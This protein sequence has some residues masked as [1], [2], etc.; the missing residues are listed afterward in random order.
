MGHL[1]KQ[2]LSTTVFLFAIFFT[3]RGNALPNADIVFV[4]QIPNP[5]DFASANATFGNHLPTVDAIPRGGDLYIRYRDGTLKNLTRTAGLGNSGFQGVSSIAVRDPAVHWNGQKIIF[6]MVAGS[7]AEQYQVRTFHWQLYEMTGL[8]KDETPVVTRVPGQPENYNN[9]TPL[10][11]TDDSIIF[12]SD[13]P[14]NG[15][16]HLYPQRDEYESQPTTTG[17]WSLNPLTGSLALLDHTPSGAFNPTLDSY[18]RIVY[19]RWDHLQRDQQA[20]DTT[21]YGAFNF[22]SEAPGS[23]RISSSLEVFPEER[24]RSTQMNPVATTHSFNHFFPWQLNEDGTEHETLNHVGRHELHGYFDRSFNDDDNLQEHYGNDPSPTSGEIE[25]FLHIREDP[26][27]PGLYYGIDTPEFRTHAAGQIVSLTGAPTLNADQMTLTYI[28]DRST[29]RTDDDSSHPEHTGLYRDPLPLSDGALVASHTWTKVADSN[30]G[31]D[32]APR[33]R[34][35]FRLKTLKKV[36]A[37]W[38]PD[39]LLTS[40]IQGSVSYFTP[41]VRA[42]YVGAL[43]E[44]Q[45]VELIA[46]SRPARR[47]SHVQAPEQSIFDALGVHVDTLKAELAQKGLALI[48]MRNVTSRDGNDLQQPFNLRIPGSSLS[49]VKTTGKMYD[50]SALQIFQG[51]LI[52]GYGGTTDPEPGR[53]VLAQQLH[54]GLLAN[55]PNSNGPPASVRI[56]SDGSVAALVPARRA[57]TWQLTNEAGAPVV[58]ERYWL[59]FQPG[60]IRVCASCHGV[61]TAD[62]LGRPSPTNPPLA[63]R[64]LLSYVAQHPIPANPDAPGSPS[65][66][67]GGDEGTSKSYSLSV[68]GRDSGGR[69]IDARLFA[70]QRA[71]ILVRI[72]GGGSAERL[73]LKIKVNGA[74]CSGSGMAVTTTPDGS[75]SRSGISPSIPRRELVL[76]FTLE[77]ASAPLATQRATLFNKRASSRSQAR[78]STKILRQVCAALQKFR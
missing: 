76:N 38:V 14:R 6:S 8:G 1:P 12:T 13:R 42:S 33:S 60:E 11:G 75:A 65:T 22:A 62:Q 69:M 47:R 36:G 3:A 31:T 39:A 10:Y 20:D 74:R 51:D 70:Q 41:D 18:G 37:L 4:A 2:L 17:L 54:D 71:Q 16:A 23:A 26:L 32:A 61:N 25:N 59:T 53:R 24:V 29:A 15:E 68:R 46:R 73:G 7:P 57:L 78:L 55:P 40:G 5:T 35:D 52:R 66:G 30:I 21:A 49:S 77:G 48:V 58:R 34:Y 63:L 19:T 56:A 44:L 28:T 50:V 67:G 45:P 64:E 43:W 9:I 27:H 72:T